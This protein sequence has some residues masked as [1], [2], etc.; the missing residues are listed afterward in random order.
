MSGGAEVTLTLLQLLVAV[1]LDAASCLAVAWGVAG[2]AEAP[3]TA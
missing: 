1:V 3:A 2:A